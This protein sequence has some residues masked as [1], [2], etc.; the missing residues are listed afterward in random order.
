M[1]GVTGEQRGVWNEAVLV[2][3]SSLLPCTYHDSYPMQGSVIQSMLLCG[4]N[5]QFVSH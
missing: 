5:G 1:A 3:A 4:L 2:I